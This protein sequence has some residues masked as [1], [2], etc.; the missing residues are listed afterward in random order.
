MDTTDT[1]GQHHNSDQNYSKQ[2]VSFFCS[3]DFTKSACAKQKPVRCSGLITRPTRDNNVDMDDHAV[4]PPPYQ[5]G[6]DSK[7]EDLCQPDFDRI[8]K[9]TPGPSSSGQLETTG[10]SSSGR[11]VATEDV[12]SGKKV[13]FHSNTHGEQYI[14]KFDDPAKNFKPQSEEEHSF[15]IKY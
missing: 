3:C 9:M 11:P 1:F 13:H 15:T 5:A 8:W 10:A 12:S 6:S 14:K 2:F 7:R 4:L